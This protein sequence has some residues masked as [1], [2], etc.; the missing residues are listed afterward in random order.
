[1]HGTQVM[2]RLI[3]HGCNIQTGTGVYNDMHEL[4]EHIVNHSEELACDK[5]AKYVLQALCDKGRLE[6]GCGNLLPFHKDGRHHNAYR[7]WCAMGVEYLWNN[8]WK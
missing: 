7:N 4:L 2:Q 1:M 3:E 8:G 5:H 6:A